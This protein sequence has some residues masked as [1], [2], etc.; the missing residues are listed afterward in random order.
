MA[1]DLT[2]IKSENDF[3]SQHYL[4]AI[5]DG[6]LKGLLK[7]WEPAEEG[8]EDKTATKPP[9]QELGKLSKSYFKL[10]GE[11]E[12]EKDP[13]KRLRLQNAFLVEFFSV[14]GYACTPNFKELEDQERVPLLAEVAKANGAPVLWILPVLDSS[15]EGFA[16]LTQ[17]LHPCQ[18]GDG[19]A[20][21]EEHLKK[22]FE[23]I[24]TAGVFGMKEPPRWVVLASD[25]QIVLIDREKW[26]EKRLMRFFLTDIF[27]RRE[28]S[29]LKVLSALLHRDSV[30]PEGRGSVLDELDENSHKH[31]HGVSEDLKYALRESIELIGN[32]A[33]RYLREVSK[34]KVFG[35]DIAKELTLE[36]LR[37]MYRILFLLYMEAR[38]ELGY[39][40][41]KSEAYLEGYSI[42]SLRELEKVP[43][44]TD[45]AKNGFYIH[46]SI[47]L[48]FRLIYNGFP[49]QSSQQLHLP[50]GTQQHTFRIPPLKSHLFDPSR[51]PLLAKVKIRNHVLQRVIELMSLSRAKGARERPG[52]ISYAQLGINQLGAVY[53]ALLSYQGFFAEEDLYEVKKA[54]AK[55]D[56][57]EIAYFVKAGDLEKYEPEEKYPK[58]DG[59]LIPHAKGRFIYRLAGRDREKSASYYTPEVLTRCLVKYALKELLKGKT[60]DQILELTVCEPAMGSAAFLNETINQLA[61]AYLRLKEKELGEAIP[62][63]DYARERQKVKMYIADR[64]VFGV[65]LNPMAAELAEVSV[66]LNT[67]YSPDVTDGKAFIP[68]F[69][70]QLVTGNSLVGARRQVF[71]SSLLKD[72]AKWLKSVPERIEPGKKRRKEQ[73]YHFLLPDCGMADYNEPVIK[74][75]APT[76]IEAIKEWKQEFCKPFTEIE[77]EQLKVLSDA[78]DRLWDRHAQQLKNVRGRTTDALKV[79]GQRGARVDGVG[80]TPIEWKDKVYRQEILSEG[81]RASSPYRRLKLAMD[82]WCALWFWP[83]ESAGLLPSRD[84]LLKDLSLILEGKVYEPQGAGAQG[85]LFAETV[86]KADQIKFLD[87]FGF[88]DVEEITKNN[89]R[90]VLAVKLAN[91]FRFID[92]ELEFADLFLH[93]GGF[94]LTVGNPPWIKVEWKEVALLADADPIYALKKLRGP[95]L[96]NLR[97]GLLGKAGFRKVFFSEFEGTRATQNFIGGLQNYP[98]L[99]GSQSNLYKCFLPNAWNYGSPGGVCAF[100][101]PEGVYDAT[102][103]QQLRCGAFRRLVAHFQFQNELQLFAEIHHNKIY[104]LNIYAARPKKECRFLNISNLFSPKT[105]DECFSGFGDGEVPGIKEFGEWCTQGHAQRI[106]EV[107]EGLLLDL[108]S[109]FSS[110]DTDRKLENSRLPALH[111]VGVADVIR[112]VGKSPIKFIDAIGRFVYSEK[113][114]VP[115]DVNA[116]VIKRKTEIPSSVDGLIF[117]GSHWFVANPFYRTPKPVCNLPSDFENLSL[118]FVEEEFLP[119]TNFVPAKDWQSYRGCSR[120][121]P[122]RETGV[123]LDEFRLLCRKMIDVR[124]ERTLV[125]AIIP[126]RSGHTGAGVSFSFENT[127]DLLQA[128]VVFSSV[129]ADFLL[130]ISGK[131]NF[132]GDSVRTFP[133]ADRSEAIVRVLMLNCVTSHF[134]GLWSKSWRQEFSGNTWKKADPRLRPEAFLNLSSEWSQGCGLRSAYE[135]R[136][137]LVELDVICALEAGLTLAELISIYSAQFPLLQQYEEDTWYDVN[138]EIVFTSNAQGLRNIGLA[139]SRW[140]EI[141]ETKAG[142]V[143]ADVG[144]EDEFVTHRL[145]TEYIAPFVKCDRVSDYALAWGGFERELGLGESRS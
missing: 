35:K 52:R 67:I 8:G 113:W 68:W 72:E 88:V 122:W 40:P 20:P 21:G 117:E 126:P 127:A 137:A 104:S 48:L 91:D 136:Q 134:K 132:S 123:V 28:L 43:L 144:S 26:P 86:P 71:D 80:P 120:G 78:I 143:V 108:A 25:A 57:L 12:T 103:G 23:A 18:F 32:E 27:E 77:I 121:L 59:K 76:Q 39:V 85:N 101:H 14:L 92:W 84:E 22:D 119:R 116:G 1:I 109:L 111:S 60:A 3:Y 102:D 98:D 15:G 65:D 124:A 44:T 47:Q 19:Q 64:N 30:C 70:M 94:D 45:D 31:A 110:S 4:Y 11:L 38:P 112:K 145:P 5:L 131:T 97:G 96:A 118:A 6:D 37:Y 107:D 141:R 115:N 24:V 7:K 51:T 138:G 10:R 128:A 83:I 13:A 93:R 90:L 42:E 99:A 87:E 69:G 41:M 74:Q 58:E 46:Q 95:E 106:V 50:Q 139:R 29:T 79:W 34:E 82:Y 62:H 66:W 129:I 135:R 49:E 130:K 56:E 55:Y 63:E 53:E 73:I 54:D 36:C 33:V 100:I 133:T 9:F 17:S 140:E 16:P 114:H 142:T 81:V 61:E 75:L 125:P 105:I 89:P 2:G